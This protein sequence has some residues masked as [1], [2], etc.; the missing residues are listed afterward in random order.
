MSVEAPASGSIHTDGTL[1]TQT[2]APEPSRAARFDPAERRDWRNRRKIRARR[3][4][5]R[6]GA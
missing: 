6:G 2:S 3:P 1:N 4:N 5:M